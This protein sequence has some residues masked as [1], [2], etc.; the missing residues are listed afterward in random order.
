MTLSTV[1]GTVDPAGFRS[2][3]KNPPRSLEQLKMMNAIVARSMER[4]NFISS[5]QFL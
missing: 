5:E 1:T 4:R 2:L 3:P